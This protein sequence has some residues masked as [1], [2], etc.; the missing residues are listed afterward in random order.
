MFLLFAL[1]AGAPQHFSTAIH[2]AVIAP[3]IELWRSYPIVASPSGIALDPTVLGLTEGGTLFADVI[4]DIGDG[5][6]G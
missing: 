3:V 2:R 4:R 5:A 1:L 6:N